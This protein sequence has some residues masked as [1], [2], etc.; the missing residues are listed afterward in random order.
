M[1]D[2]PA[3]KANQTTQKQHTTPNTPNKNHQTDQPISEVKRQWKQWDEHRFGSLGGTNLLTRVCE[4]KTVLLHWLKRHSLLGYL[5]PLRPRRIVLW[6]N[7]DSLAQRKR[8]S[9]HASPVVS[10]CAEWA[11]DTYGRSFVI[12]DLAKIDH[13]CSTLFPQDS[14]M[15]VHLLDGLD[16]G[17]AWLC[18]SQKQRS[19]N[20]VPSESSTLL[21]IGGHNWMHMA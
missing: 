11:R 1:S 6:A 19:I 15:M 9:S 13:D 18:P 20:S 17:E 12:K 4:C 8:L 5:M 21:K 14:K 7:Q 2:G 3:T 10:K 16:F